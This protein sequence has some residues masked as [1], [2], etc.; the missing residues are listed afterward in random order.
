MLIFHSKV[1]Y[2][3]LL[4]FYDYL[5]TNNILIYPGKTTKYSTFRIGSIGALTVDHMNTL[6]GFIGLFLKEH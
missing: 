5:A 6:L 3:K 4:E 1:T 2:V